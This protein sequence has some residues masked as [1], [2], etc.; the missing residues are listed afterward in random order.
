M[1]SPMYSS[2]H[3]LKDFFDHL[4]TPEGLL[5]VF[6]ID[7]T[8]SHP[9]EPAFQ[10]ATFKKH[11]KIFDALFDSLSE[12]ERD[13]FGN[14]MVFYS[15]ECQ[16]IE[17]EAPSWMKRAQQKGYKTVALTASLTSKLRK[18]CLVQKR[19][20]NLLNL[21]FDFSESFS[22]LESI[23]FDQFDP[24]YHSYPHYEKGIL[25]SNGESR[26]I[27]KGEVL[28]DFLSHLKETPKSIYFVD[29]RPINLQ[30]VHT[31]L[32]EKAPQIDYHGFHYQGALNTPSLDI[33]YDQ[34]I[35]KI[36]EMVKETKEIAK[37]FNE[38]E[39]SANSELNQ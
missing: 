31:A 28:M 38:Y 1:T 5:L 17:K 3:S 12:L 27:Y 14:L 24:T 29:D 4:P 22:H 11:K 35:L 37:D 30:A 39:K 7:Y 21:G 9:I 36:Q 16:L 23:R 19:I 34:L 10:L 2:I 13:I 20:K 32:K 15:S 25:F 33:A 26:K 8:L 18:E 6:D